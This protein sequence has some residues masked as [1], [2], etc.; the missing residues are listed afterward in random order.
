[1]NIKELN[2]YLKQE[3]RNTNYRIS[4]PWE[5]LKLKYLKRLEVSNYEMTYLIMEQ[6]GEW[7]IQI[8]ERGVV[9]KS[10]SFKTEKEACIF[11]KELFRLKQKEYRLSYKNGN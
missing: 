7:K 8:E 3:L 5:L 11:F 9:D 2:T 6:G 4:R 1:M 10:E